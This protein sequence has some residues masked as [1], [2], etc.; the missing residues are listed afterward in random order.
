MN[1]RDAVELL[2]DL[3]AVY[4]PSG[5]EAEAVGLLVDRAA[6]A[7]LRTS[8]DGAGNFVGERGDGPATVVLLGHVDTVEGFIPPAV[9]DDRLHAR[10]A[11]DAKGP[12]AM[13]VAATARATIPQGLRVVVVGAVE[14]EAPSS[15]GAHFVRDRYQPDAAVIGEPSGTSGIT[16]GY[17][18]RIGLAL[19]ARQAR[20][21]TAAEGRS[22]AARTAEWWTRLEE[23]CAQ[24]NDERRVFDRIDAHL[25]TFQTSSD[26]FT[27]RVDLRGSLR[28]P[29][30]PPLDELRDRC[31]ALAAGWGS[32]SFD[33]FVPAFRSDRRNRLVAALLRSVRREGLDPTFKLKTGTSDMNVV[34]PA[35]R[36]PIVAY[37]PGDSRLDHTPEEHVELNDYHRAI[38]VLTRV[39]GDRLA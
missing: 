13:F 26:G 1:D 31:S 6:A 4:S 15:K 16:L 39:L 25:A 12:L 38:R 18:G 21:H 5:A 33:G 34:G 19:V 23:Y 29:V 32:A 3:C 22:V 24:R 35:W 8:I 27:D 28:L 10:G 20:T 14:E 2:R 7:G 9:T 36:C 17:K 30:D 11:V 37:G